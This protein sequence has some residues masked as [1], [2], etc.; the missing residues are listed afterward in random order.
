[1]KSFT[2]FSTAVAAYAGFARALLVTGAAE[3]FAK[4]VTGGGVRY[5]LCFPGSC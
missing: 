4:G 1:M 2:L 3:G 5:T